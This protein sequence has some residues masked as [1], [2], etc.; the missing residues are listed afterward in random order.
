MSSAVAVSASARLV[1][2][3]FSAPLLMTRAMKGGGASPSSRQSMVQ[4]SSA[5]KAATSASRSTRSPSAPIPRAT[6]TKSTG[7]KSVSQGVNPW[8]AIPWA[9]IP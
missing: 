2:R 3:N 5:V 9:T 1:G 8:A 7:G 6:A 4:N